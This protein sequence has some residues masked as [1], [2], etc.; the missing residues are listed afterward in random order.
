MT[1]SDAT[2]SHVLQ[3]LVRFHVL[4][5]TSLDTIISNSDAYGSLRVALPSG[6]VF[7]ADVRSAIIKPGP[8]L[9]ETM[10]SVPDVQRYFHAAPYSLTEESVQT[11]NPSAAHGY[12]DYPAYVAAFL[13]A[14]IHVIR[15]HPNAGFLKHILPALDKV[16]AKL[17]T[18]G[19]SA[20]PWI[21]QLREKKELK[22]HFWHRDVHFGNILVD[23]ESGEWKAVL[24]WEFAGLGVCRSITREND[25][26]QNVQPCFQTKTTD[27]LAQTVYRLSQIP[28]TAPEYDRAQ[29]T[30]KTW[31]SRFSELLRAES[32]EAADLWTSATDRDNVLGPEGNALSDLREFLRSCLEVGVRGWGSVEAAKGRWREVVE[33]RLQ[34]LGCM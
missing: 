3:Q 25:A 14:Y 7:E 13:S 28:E 12:A 1:M 26:D 27:P 11:L 18:P 15:V 5:L 19:T 20:E 16:V 22:G 4:A 23:P 29:E 34:A 33:S 31:P 6:S 17:E 8:V 9:E 21:Q 10:W 2:L 30:I 32:S 24:D